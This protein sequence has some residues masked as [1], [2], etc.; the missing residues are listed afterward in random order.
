[1]EVIAYGHSF[2]HPA[3]DR[4]GIA[5]NPAAFGRRAAAATGHTGGVQ[6]GGGI[7]QSLLRAAEIH[8][9]AARRHA[10]RTV[11]SEIQAHAE[12]AGKARHIPAA[13]CHQDRGGREGQ[14]DHQGRAG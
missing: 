11:Q 3:A 12:V 4:L 14:R 7:R 6:A 8:P 1:M 10:G 9:L 5:D 2:L 13:H